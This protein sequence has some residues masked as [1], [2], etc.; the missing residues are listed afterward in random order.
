MNVDE[1]QGSWSQVI[2]KVREQWGRLTEDEL[3]RSEGRIE[4]LSGIL[5]E[6]YG[7]SKDEAAKEL[8]IFFKKLNTKH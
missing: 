7:K 3:L 6:K 2:G 5:Q 4:Y 8:E 1:I